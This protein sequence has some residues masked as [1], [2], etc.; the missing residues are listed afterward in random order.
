MYKI[1]PETEGRT[2]EDIEIHF[3]DNSK[4]LTDNKIPRRSKQKA[5]SSGVSTRPASF[6][7]I[8]DIN[9]NH[10]ENGFANPGF[11]ADNQHT[12]F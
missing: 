10:Y 9:K 1:L 3:A 5:E 11:V 2:L 4:K 6:V 12:K 7:T 8:D